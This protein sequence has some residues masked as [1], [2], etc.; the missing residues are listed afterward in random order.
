MQITPRRSGDP[1]GIFSFNNGYGFATSVSVFKR[2]QDHSHQCIL[3]KYSVVGV[4]D[5]SD[6]FRRIKI[7]NHQPRMFGLSR[8][9][10]GCW[11]RSINRKRRHCFHISAKNGQSCSTRKCD[12]TSVNKPNAASKLKQMNSIQL[13]RYSVVGIWRDRNQN[14]SLVKT[15]KL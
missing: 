4:D 8:R 3:L 9:M 6:G 11:N 1:I 5:G 12:Y 14:K 7:G 2:N 15:K 13:K 10:T